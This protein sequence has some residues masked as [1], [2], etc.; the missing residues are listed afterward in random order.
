M[1]GI[2]LGWLGTGLVLVL[3]LG[4]GL[5]PDWWSLVLSCSGGGAGLTV[6]CGGSS[7]TGR[8]CFDCCG[9]VLLAAV[10]GTGASGASG[11]VP[12]VLPLVLVLVLVL[13]LAL[14]WR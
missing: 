8:W 1:V 10:L 11:A 14:C 4:L 7:T 3:R 5:V 9:R 2:V 6:P 12:V 13:V